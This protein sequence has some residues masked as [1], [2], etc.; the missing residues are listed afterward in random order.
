MAKVW[1][2]RYAFTDGIMEMEGKIRESG[3]FRPDGNWSYIPKKQWH[4]TKAEAIA[5]AEEMHIAKLKSMDKQIK[6]ISALKF[7]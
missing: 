7:E 6:K 4:H 5:R 2:T 1:V 3:Y